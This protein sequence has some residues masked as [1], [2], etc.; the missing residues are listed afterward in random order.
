METQGAGVLPPEKLAVTASK[1]PFGIG[2]ESFFFVPGKT[3]LEIL[4]EACPEH[5]GYK[6]IVFVG[7]C[8]ILPE[9]YHCVRPKT[10]HVISINIAPHGG[11]KGK[12][13]LRTIVGLAL[14][15]AAPIASGAIL[16]TTLASAAVFGTTYGAIFS[17][18]LGFAGNA[19]LNVLI[20]TA[21]PRAPSL[22]G[23]GS[24]VEDSQTYFI[25]GARNRL[26]PFQ[27]VPEVLGT[28]RI[29]PFLGGQTY[30]EV[31]GEFVYSRQIFV[32]S[33]GKVQVQDERLGD[34]PLS[35]Y[36]EVSK[37]DFFDGNLA[38]PSTIYPAFVDPN[39]LNIGLE[40]EAEDYS[41]VLTAQDTD[42][43]I[44]QISFPR[45][46]YAVGPRKGSIDNYFVDYEIR[47]RPESGGDYES[48]TYR[49]LR[50]APNAFA[51]A[52]R[53]VLPERGQYRFE[54]IN[55]TARNDDIE[56]G[57]GAYEMVWSGLQSFQNSSPV[58]ATYPVSGKTIRIRGT[59]QLT[60]AVDD[61]N[62]KA[63]RLIPDWNGEEWVDDQVTSNP[64][65]IARYLLTSE[66][67]YDPLD[68]DEY[69]GEWLEEWHA[70]CEENG[71]RYNTYIDYEADLEELL[72]EVATAGR[73]SFTIIDNKY[74]LIIDRPSD[75][76]VN[77]ITQRKSYDYS[78][79]R[80]FSK[81]IHALRCPFLNEEKGYI[82][83]EVTVYADGYDKNNATEFFTQDFPGV[84]NAEQIWKL[85]RYYLAYMEYRPDMHKVTM[86]I[87]HIVG[88]RGK[89]VKFSQ[90]VA[91][92]GLGTGRVKSVTLDPDDESWVIGVV[93]DEEIAMSEGQTYGAEF[94]LDSGEGLKVALNTVAGKSN[95]LTFA[96]RVAVD[97]APAAGDL[98]SWGESQ[99]VTMDAL[100]HSVVPQ[101]ELTA[102]VYLVRY[103]PQIYDA[104]KGAVPEL[105]TVI[106]VPPEF[107]R[108]SPPVLGAI[109]S[110]E[111]VQVY[112]LDG[113]ISS[114]M[115]I[116]LVNG[117]SGSMEPIVSIRRT[118]QSAFEDANMVASNDRRVVVEGLEQGVAY[119]LDIRYR[120]IGGPSLGSNV[121]SA[122]LTLNGVV[123][124]GNSA[125]PPDVENFDIT[126]RSDTVFLSW[127][128]VRVI[129]L[130]G[131]E[132]RFQPVTSGASWESA[133]RVGPRRG[134][135]DLSAEAPHRI[136]TYMIKAFD[137]SGEPVG[138]YSENAATV[139]TTIGQ[140]D[141]LN[142][143]ATI[144]AHSSWDGTFN[145]TSESGGALQLGSDV[146]WDDLGTW[147]DLGMW[148]YADGEIVDGGSYEFEGPDLGD[149]YTCVVSA[150]LIVSGANIDDYIDDVG[151]WDSRE[152]WDGVDPSQYDV[153]L[154]IATTND[155][156]SGSP[157]YSAY[158]EIQAIGE[159]TFRHPKFK[160]V[161]TSKEL[162]VTPVVSE[163]TVVIDA[164]DRPESARNISSGTGGKR[165]NFS[166]YGGSSFAA[167]CVPSVTFGVNGAYDD[168]T[169]TADA[170][171][172]DVEFFL[173]S[174]SVDR[175][176]DYQAQGYGRKS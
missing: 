166:D 105:E 10:G 85:G 42:E 27:G 114:R 147:D 4:N 20:P 25:Q 47:Y 176:F 32:H 38:D 138:N 8:L 23:S 83:D 141:G 157:V 151:L 93:V 170:D 64:A 91:M 162:N 161:L 77:H 174:V 30:A 104:D 125:P 21:K 142:A 131:Y 101:N 132:I 3:L 71:F 136:G 66:F 169:Y 24:K 6:A 108:P 45:G 70:F 150:A 68:D 41:V 123:F 14:A 144:E 98:F 7:D 2:V 55:L 168:M 79:E 90:D 158:R 135:D 116:R 134:K 86:D 31:S 92:I 60:G 78:Y 51:L 12:N 87:E 13:P 33:L 48:F 112:N 15:F 52:H 149:S 54:V 94:W 53:F 50:P 163:C 167:D 111:A 67:A 29:T 100:I 154:L 121:I 18:A 19:L 106:T 146:Q 137:R 44:V 103:A 80:T 155:D 160:L 153:R 89:R 11:K 120:R 82:Q 5:R 39:D 9:Y 130:A 117:N 143:V 126:V 56:N 46:L 110:D 148:D 140:L 156:P 1:N 58:K 75:I 139:V 129:D 118:G 122:P 76:I 65:S 73:A 164:P 84:T 97:D 152:T 72:N 145:G 35:L 109:Q 128:P 26:A 61:Y 43:A 22:T 37:E 62:C 102:E 119:D 40:I 171:G 172:F 115:V 28:H 63:S 69:D 81:K 96:A 99:A 133:L 124:E 165:V 95:E 159:Y 74:S 36:E 88:T 59:K 175:V 17:A 113:S 34:T 173:N 49:E 16:G 57:R 127:D 107:R